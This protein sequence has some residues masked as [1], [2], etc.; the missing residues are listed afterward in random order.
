MPR[1]SQIAYLCKSCK[2]A[3]LLPY[4]YTYMYI[5][6]IAYDCVESSTNSAH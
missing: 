2:L 5:Q 6:Y 1:Q 4:T 3:T